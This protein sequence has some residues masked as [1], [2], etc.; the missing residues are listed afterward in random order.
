MISQKPMQFR[1]KEARDSFLTELQK[2]WF[3]KARYIP[4]NKNG[5]FLIEILP[6]IKE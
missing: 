1:S 4:K 6:R 2:Y 3:L 5:R